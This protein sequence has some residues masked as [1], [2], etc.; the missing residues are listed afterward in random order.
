MK[1]TTITPVFVDF[2]PEELNEGVIYISETYKTIVHRC[3]CGCGEEVVTPLSP[4]DWQLI[5]EGKLITIRP[6]IGNWNY[7][8]QSHYL[9]TR[10]KVEWAGGMTKLQI[11]RVQERDRKD[12][13]L[14]I[15]QII[16]HKT[17]VTEHDVN[18][19]TLNSW[20]SDLWA[21]LKN[22]WSH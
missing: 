16:S 21:A 13:E 18:K 3:C 6:S 22:W 2:I 4:V 10:N 15:A 14:Y 11:Q 8:C 9:I 1:R 12:K 17:T 19:A 7:P 20:L 5:R